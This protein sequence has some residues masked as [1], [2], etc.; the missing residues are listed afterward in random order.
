MERIKFPQWYRSRQ[1]G[2]LGPMR[3]II[4]LSS[5][6]SVTSAYLTHFLSS[7]ICSLSRYTARLVNGYV[8]KF[9][10]QQ[11]A[12]AITIIRRKAGKIDSISPGVYL[13]PLSINKNMIGQPTKNGPRISSIIN[14]NVVSMLGLNL[15]NVVTSFLIH[16]R[17]GEQKC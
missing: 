7:M 12:T 17:Y 2:S 14:M 9:K 11:N 8:I 6:I 4:P 3:W 15:R 5:T 13:A 1:Q 10:T 16:H